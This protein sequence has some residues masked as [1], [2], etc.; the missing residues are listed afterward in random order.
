MLEAGLSHVVEYFYDGVAVAYTH[1]PAYVVD[2]VLW[3]SHE[4]L[5]FPDLLDEGRLWV[6]DGQAV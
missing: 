2:D 3:R 6:E 5:L 1:L 4:L